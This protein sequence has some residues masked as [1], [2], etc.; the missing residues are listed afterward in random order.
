[1]KIVLTDCKT[2]TRGEIDLSV[3]DSIGETVYYDLTPAD[4]LIERIADADAVI[5]NKTVIT[6]EV[7]AAAKNLKYIGLFAT[8]FNNIDVDYANS[9]GITVCNAG[10]YSTNAVAQHVFACILN[11]TNRVADYTN[12]VNDGGWKNSETF[13][14][15]IFRMQELC[16]R[17]IGIIGYGSIGREVAKIAKAFSMEILAY[18]RNP[19]NE[20][21]VKFVDLDTLVSE[22]DFVTVHCP[23]NKDSE[24]MFDEKMFAKFKDGAFFVN[25]ARGGVVDETA[26]KNALV[27]GKL[28]GAA[29]DV[30]TTEPMQESCELVNLPGLSVTPHVAWAPVETRERLLGIVTDNLKSYIAGTPKNVV[31]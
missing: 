7:M 31:K 26:L 21:G 30:L 17:K 4:K 3:F 11:H 12:F 22:S 6:A 8:G 29:I 10:S 19:I 14:P 25:T 23:L 5:C 1:M 2:V 18:K 9:H 16:G 20:E 28:S 15:F 13:S 27:S 24:K